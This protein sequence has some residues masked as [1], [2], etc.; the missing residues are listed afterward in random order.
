M[1]PSNFYAAYMKRLSLWKGIPINEK[2]DF[3]MICECEVD[4]IEI[5]LI[6]ES[7]FSIN[8]LENIMTKE[9]FSSIRDFL[10]WALTNYN[11][12]TDFKYEFNSYHPFS[13]FSKSSYSTPGG[14]VA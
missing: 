7:E 9:D 12:K 6:G 4:F 14:M 13:S 1:R 10:E 8:L 3:D 11:C 5:L 2:E